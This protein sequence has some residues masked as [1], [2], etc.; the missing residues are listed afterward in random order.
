MSSVAPAPRFTRLLAGVVLARHQWQ[1]LLVVLT[2]VI[3][4]LALTPTPPQE[5]SFGWDKANHTL[6]FLAL[7]L[8]GCLGLRGTRRGMLW[9]LLGAF[10]LGCAIELVQL[11]VPGRSCEWQD[12][13][14]DSAGIALGLG[15]ALVALRLVNAGR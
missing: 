10:A 13:L 15:I 12:L 9:V 14:A 6:A 4:Y 11:F 3:C 7:T 2:L 1:R 5:A 8:A